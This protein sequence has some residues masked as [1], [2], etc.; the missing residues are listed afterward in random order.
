M[1]A[2]EKR[3]GKCRKL[4][5]TAVSTGVRAFDPHVTRGWQPFCRTCDWDAKHEPHRGWKRLLA[6]SRGIRIEITEPEYKAIINCNQCRWCRGPLRRWGGYWIDRLDSK[7]NY[8]RG[9]VV[10]CCVWCNRY[11]NDLPLEAWTPMIEALINRFGVG[12]GDARWLDWSSL[13]DQYASRRPDLSRLEIGET[14]LDL[15]SSVGGG[16]RTA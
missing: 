5:S 12:R 16:L 3:C 14:T 8:E 9:N 11:K 1:T 4:Y 10:P 15:F 2:N 6:D 7:R 13:G